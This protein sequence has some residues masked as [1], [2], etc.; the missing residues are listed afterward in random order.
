M[1]VIAALTYRKGRRRAEVDFS[2]PFDA[3][4]DDF[5]WIGLFEPS[6]AELESVRRRYG[7]HELA[8]EDARSQDG[9]PKLEVYGQQLFVR[10]RTVQLADDALKFGSTSFFV[11]RNY[12]VT[13]RMGSSDG[14]AG[15]RQRVEEDPDLLLNG[16]DFVLHALMDLII[17]HYFPPL[18]RIAT[19]LDLFEEAAFEGGLA[20]EQ[21]V[22]I[23]ALRR[24]LLRFQ[25]QLV[26]MEEVCAKLVHLDLPG[27]DT[28]MKP[29]FRDLAD[30]VRRAETLTRL[31]REVLGSV[32]ETSAL[33]EQQQQ[34]VITRQLAA[35]A[36]I[37]AVPTAIAGIYGMNFRFMPEL[38]HRWGYPVVLLVILTI[39][40]VLWRRFRG[41]GWL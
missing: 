29:Y 2:S 28:A 17:D 22:E 15:L 24:Q 19:R 39:C 14:H 3:D 23:F 26:P 37:L 16:P 4:A 5:E 21:T 40:L 6:E 34:N 30:H 41:L 25:R 20:R 13:V 31:Q 38:E 33:I 32:M 9:L 1:S 10:T 27:V 18:E 8:V 35:W 7:L 12:I 36:A 11:S